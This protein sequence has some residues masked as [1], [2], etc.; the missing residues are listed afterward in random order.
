MNNQLG[1]AGASIVAAHS[2]QRHASVRELLAEVSVA[3]ITAAR[4]A[5]ARF[6]GR[7]DGAAVSCEQLNDPAWLRAT[8]VRTNSAARRRHHLQRAVLVQCRDW[9]LGA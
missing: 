9:W 7:T 1:A 3:C 5:A 6:G 8:P 2:A 4:Q